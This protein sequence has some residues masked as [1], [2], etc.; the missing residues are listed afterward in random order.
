MSGKFT[1]KKQER[2]TSKTLIQ[3]LFGSGSQSISQ[4]PVR[5]ITKSVNPLPNNTPVQVLISV[6]KKHFKHAV[7]RNKIKRQIREAYRKNKHK[8]INNLQTSST[9]QLIAFV[10]MGN[11]EINTKKVEEKIV[12]LLDRLKEIMK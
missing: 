11:E 1:F 7:K 5:L 3:E 9:T 10:W 8:L 2:L 6:S 4:Y 12:K